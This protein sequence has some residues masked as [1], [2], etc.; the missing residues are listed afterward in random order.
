MDIVIKYINQMTYYEWVM[1]IGFFL[2]VV[3]LEIALPKEKR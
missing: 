1:M 3:V 2:T